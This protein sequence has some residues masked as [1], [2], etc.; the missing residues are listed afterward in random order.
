M[1]APGFAWADIFVSKYFNISER[2]KFRFD[3]QFYNA[4]N[5]ANFNFPGSSAGIPGVGSTLNNAFASTGTASPPTSLLGSFL[6]GDNSV[7]MIA[8]SGR[9]E[10]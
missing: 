7:R 5:H 4:F 6:G 8:I 3:A 1:F 10:F 9:L 2:V